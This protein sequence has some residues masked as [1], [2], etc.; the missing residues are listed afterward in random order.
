MSGIHDTQYLCL[1]STTHNTYVWYPR[2]TIFMSDIHDKQYLCT[3]HI[4]DFMYYMS[5]P[6][7]CFPYL[8]SVA[9]T[10]LDDWSRSR[11][12]I[13]DHMPRSPM[14]YTPWPDWTPCQI[15]SK[16]VKNCDSHMVT[17]SQTHTI[18]LPHIL[19]RHIYWFAIKFRLNNFCTFLFNVL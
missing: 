17:H 15:L 5:H 9:T 14:S 16:C 1:V 10:T 6:I 2:Y 11:P 7:K 12:E 4:S 8:I 19:M 3:D 18:D 13:C